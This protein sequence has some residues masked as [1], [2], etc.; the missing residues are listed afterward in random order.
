MP[1]KQYLKKQSPVRFAI[2]FVVLFLLLYYF[3]IL[4]FGITLKGNYYSPFLAKHLNYI[5]ALRWVLLHSAAQMLTWLGF[6]TR[7]SKYELLV[8]GHGVIKLIYTCLGLGVMS[9]FAAFIIAYPKTL[10]SKLI[11]LVTGILGIQI[12]NIIRFMLLALYWTRSKTR[13]ID[14]HLIFDIIIYIIIAITLYHWVNSKKNDPRAA[15]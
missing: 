5:D 4:F 11:L 12:L 15:N 7:V 13:I 1:V 6:I 8:A 3:N 14:H 2:V 9:F 10:R